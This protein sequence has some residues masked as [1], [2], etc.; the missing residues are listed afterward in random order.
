MGEPGHPT[1][2]E[3]TPKEAAGEGGEAPAPAAAVETAAPAASGE[4]A[5]IPVPGS[6]EKAKE[7]GAGGHAG[8]EAPKA[9]TGEGVGL[10]TAADPG[11][12]DKNAAKLEVP[13]PPAQAEA[14]E[15]AVK[16]G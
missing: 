11:A 9:V 14:E 3:A 13:P 12:E 1:R 6:A 8:G 7:A 15:E 5:A 10:V 4:A 16:A 2:Q